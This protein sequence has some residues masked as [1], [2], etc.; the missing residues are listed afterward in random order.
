[1]P[2]T[3]FWNGNASGSQNKWSDGNIVAILW[4]QMS[5]RWH[6]FIILHDQLWHITNELPSL[7]GVS[8]AANHRTRNFTSLHQ[9]LFYINI[10]DHQSCGF[11]IK[12]IRDWSGRKKKWDVPQCPNLSP[13]LKANKAAFQLLNM[14]VETQRP[15]NKQQLFLCFR[16]QAVADDVTRSSKY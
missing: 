6:V 2:K 10:F 16:L 7:R 14:K 15:K 1:M 4:S 8:P 5:K 13:D 12:L 3:D 9:S 11:L